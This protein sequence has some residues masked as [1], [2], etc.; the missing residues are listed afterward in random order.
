MSTKYFRTLRAEFRPKVAREETIILIEAWTR[1]IIACRRTFNAPMVCAWHIPTITWFAGFRRRN[2]KRRWIF[3]C[4]I[5]LTSWEYL[6]MR[7]W[8]S[9]R[10]T[11]TATISTQNRRIST[12]PSVYSIRCLTKCSAVIGSTR[13]HQ[14]SW[15]SGWERI[16]FREPFGQDERDRKKRLWCLTWIFGQHS[17]ASLSDRLSYNKRIQH[18]R[19][20]LHFGLSNREV[21]EGFL[22][23]LLNS[24]RGSEGMSA[25]FALQ[26]NKALKNNDID[27]ALERMKSFLAGIVPLNTM[28]PFWG[29]YIS[30]LS[31]GLSG[32]AS[33]NSAPPLTWIYLW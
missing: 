22:K 23:G 3:L 9:W 12:T 4:R 29:R 30:G 33:A 13:P 16:L 2:F 25:S 31:A 26:F 5:W 10:A 7:L 19:W 6:L 27:G 24:Y 14:H 1:L 17:A 32:F 21:R 18:R 15:S 11:T 20:V 28:L 8:K